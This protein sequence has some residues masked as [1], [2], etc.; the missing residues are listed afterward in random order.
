VDFDRDR[1][2][3]AALSRYELDP[4]LP[5]VG[6][7]GGS[8][9]AGAINK[10]IESMASAWAGPP[11]QLLHLTGARHAVALEEAAMRSTVR[12]RVVGFETEMEWFYAASD[13]VIARAGGAVAELAA[14]ATPSVLVPG[15]FGS[16]SHQYDNAAE[17]DRIGAAEVVDET[18]LS[19]L[20]P[21]I[22]SL[23]ED[24][25]ALA[26]MAEAARRLAK[27]AAA[28]SIAGALEELHG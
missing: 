12:W 21:V 9:G 16:G 28:D 15:A 23:L 10:Q 25:E 19:S 18:A 13:V 2:R 5:V 1:L 7:F 11:M 6:V 20:G 4:A 8:L 22:S 24:R 27:P 17:F 26:R 3:P 14:T